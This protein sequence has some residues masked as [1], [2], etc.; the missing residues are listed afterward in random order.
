M[1]TSLKWKEN[2]T[3]KEFCENPII[4]PK[5]LTDIEYVHVRN[6]DMQK[7]LCTAV[8]LLPLVNAT[9]R[10]IGVRCVVTVY[11]QYHLTKIILVLVKYD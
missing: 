5:I 10:L 11:F 8:V 6:R 3:N 7:W 9:I 1:D 2:I 4:I